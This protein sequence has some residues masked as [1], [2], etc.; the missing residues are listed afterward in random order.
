MGVLNNEIYIQIPAYVIETKRLT[1]RR[2]FEAEVK[3]VGPE[4]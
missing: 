4:R 3:S 1:K 2:R